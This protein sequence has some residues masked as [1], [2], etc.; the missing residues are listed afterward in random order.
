MIT[1]LESEYPKDLASN[2]A[3][4]IR[5]FKLREF[6]E[7]L[8]RMKKDS[9]VRIIPHNYIPLADPDTLS[10][11]VSIYLILKNIFEIED[12]KILIAGIESERATNAFEYY[13]D[14]CSESNLSIEYEYIVRD[15]VE[16]DYWCECDYLYILDTNFNRSGFQTKNFKVNQSI[17]VLDHHNYD[18]NR[19]EESIIEM[20]SMID[21]SDGQE[22]KIISTIF[23]SNA[24]DE[25]DRASS[26]SQLILLYLQSYHSAYF[27]ANSKSE[28]TISLLRAIYRI[29]RLGMQTDT[30]SFMYSNTDNALKDIGLFLEK[31]CN[32]KLEIEQSKI[33]AQAILRYNP[34]DMDLI[35][36][37][38]QR[39][40][41][42]TFGKNILATI[43]FLEEK[44][45]HR[46]DGSRVALSPVYLCTNYSVP[47]SIAVI[48]S[49]IKDEANLRLY[50][51]K[52]EFRSS[53][54]KVPV[55]DLAKTFKG[56]G[57]LCA[58]GGAEERAINIANEG[59]ELSEWKNDLL[60]RFNA[61]YTK[62]TKE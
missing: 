20:K 59:K 44:E 41:L 39:I 42:H 31:F 12:V 43:L 33:Q 29:C 24:E 22:K 1:Y 8:I 55:L 46:I 54:E 49:P 30:G 50:K 15:D 25:R 21:D 4:N 3:W 35:K 10:A 16:N 17:L 9:K 52:I 7:A 26:T 60:N 56:G 58:A 51:A 5:S 34:I 53:T 38:N 62:L 45:L 11:S 19:K 28:E 47:V 18:E 48:F 32:F 36:S 27:Y 40:Q 13:K 61:F 37:L 2:T 14:I 57:H 23:S 6:N